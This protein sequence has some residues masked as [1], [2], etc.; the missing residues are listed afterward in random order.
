MDYMKKVERALAV[1]GPAFIN[2]LQCC[3]RGWRCKP[4]DSIRVSDMAVQTRYW[5][6]FEVA[7]GKWKVNY[8]PKE[9][10]P[11]AEWFK[12]QGRFRHVLAEDKEH[13]V[14]WHQQQIEHAWSELLA[15]EA[16]SKGAEEAEKGQ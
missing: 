10:V 12:M 16:A 1:D 11:V 3:H 15:R 6:L 14:E 7:D 4:E 9:H 2:V 8:K 13:V 5:P